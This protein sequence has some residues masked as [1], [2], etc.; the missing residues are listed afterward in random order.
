[1][2]QAAELLLPFVPSAAEPFDLRR[3]GHLA[4]RV[5]FGLPLGE[6]ERLTRLTPQEAVARVVSGAGGEDLADL[7]EDVIATETLARAQA[8]R[9][10]RLLRGRQ[11]L[12][13]RMSLFWHGH[14]A[15]S[16]RKVQDLAAMCRQQQ[17]FD[18]LG[19]GIFDAL[20]LAI[21]K[22][23]AM[24]RWLDGAN[25]KKGRANENFAR[26]LFERFAL[27]RGA[28]A[29][30]DVQEAARAFTGYAL[31][32]GAFHFVAA[33]HDAG[34][35]QVL[36][37]EGPLGG[38][39]VIALALRHPAHA[40]FLARKLLQ[41]FVHPEPTPDE[42]AA[43]AEAYRQHGR[44]VG[45]T[46]VQ[47]LGSRLFFSARAYRSRVKSPADWCLG[48]VRSCAASAAPTAL[49]Q[50]LATLGQSLLEPP[51]VEGWHEERAWL[52]SATWLLRANA[53]ADLFMARRDT[54]FAPSAAAILEPAR[55]AE[56]RADL[57]LRLLLD[58]DVSAA[59]RA[60]V[61]AFAQSPAAAGPDGAAALLHAVALLPEAQLL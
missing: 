10:W 50:M 57:A 53:A 6:R 24:L 42:V 17:L 49:A 2:S 15:T 45:K 22:D 52:T 44:D 35:K 8:W 12:A 48:L 55:N 60:R 47:L 38:D 9:V 26:E 43:V 7:V 23:P 14:F 11:R 39:D 46:C 3:A 51:S 13:E 32:D 28:Y 29:E 1:M 58:G 19:T 61:R 34:S 27:G 20:V 54:K 5:A 37:G 56:A 18:R 33:W 4:R 41:L 30:K 59:A 16:Q 40:P 31:R 25:N 21:A 36:G